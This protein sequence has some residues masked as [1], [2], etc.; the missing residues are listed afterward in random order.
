MPLQQHTFAL[1]VTINAHVGMTPH[2]AAHQIGGLLS[3]AGWR[4]SVEPAIPQSAGPKENQIVEVRLVLN[5]NLPKPRWRVEVTKE[6]AEENGGGYETFT[7]PGGL[8]AHFALDVARGMVTVSPAQRAQLATP[9][10]CVT[11]CDYDHS[12]Y[13]AGKCRVCGHVD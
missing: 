1:R 6:F 8:S 11:G 4:A 7:E 5:R 12:V 9:Q 2:D 10:P 13:P 3:A